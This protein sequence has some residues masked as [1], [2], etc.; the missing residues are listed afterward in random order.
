MSDATFHFKP[1]T[2][3]TN[4][5]GETVFGYTL[6]NRYKYVIYEY[7]PHLVELE[8]DRHKIDGIITFL[9]AVCLASD[10]G[11]FNADNLM[12]A[13]SKR[14]KELGPRFANDVAVECLDEITGITTTLVIGLSKIEK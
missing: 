13:I 14:M 4:K 8:E 6:K 10:M 2:I 7:K 11:L 3:V 12:L 1:K 5:N 9:K